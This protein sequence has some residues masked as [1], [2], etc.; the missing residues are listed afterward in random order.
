M[1]FLIA[2]DDENSRVLLESA[3]QAQGYTVDSAVN[4]A[5]A[6]ELARRTPPDMIISDI[7]MPEMDGFDLCRM[8]KEDERLRKIPF[9]FYSATY[10]EAK[11]KQLALSLGASRYIIKPMEM[12]EFLKI[13]AAVLEEHSAHKLPVPD[14]PNR[15]NHELEQMHANR[16]E[17]KLNQKVRALEKEREA[18]Q[19]SQVNLH[20][21]SRAVEQSPAAV[22][23]SDIHGNIEFVNNAFEQISGYSRK[24]VLGHKPS[25][26]KSE[27]TPPHVYDNLWL[28]ISTGREWRGEL[29]NKKRDGEL[30]WAYATISPI[31]GDDGSITHYL[32]TQEDISVRKEYEKRLLRQANF[33][34]ITGLPNRILVMD[35]LAQAI[36]SSQR[37][38][39]D[40]AVMMVDLDDF[41]KVNDTLGH[42]AGDQILIEAARRL[43]NVVRDLDTVARLGGDE[44]LLILPA[45]EEVTG[46]Q[47]VAEKI[48]ESFSTPFEIL[49]QVIVIT[50]SIGITHLL[51]DSKDPHILIRNAEAA[52][53]RA[54]HAGRNTYRFFIQELNEHAVKRLDMENQLRQALAKGEF[55][56]CYQPQL[57]T[58]SNKIVGAEALLHWQN[59]RLGLVPSDKFIHLAES[60]GL[61]DEI[62]L[63]VLDTAIR[64]AQQW[65]TGPDRPLRIAVNFS[66]QQFQHVDIVEQVARILR[67]SGLPTQLLEME[68]TESLLLRE[69]AN[70]L[71][72]LEQLHQ[73]GVRIAIDDFGTGYS[74]LSYLK[75]FPIDVLKIDQ[76][77]I[78]DVVDDPGDA[79]LVNTII[80][81][82]R[83]LGMQVIAEGVETE[84]Q[85]NFLKGAGCELVQGYYFSKPLPAGEF[86]TMLNSRSEM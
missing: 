77:F 56:L 3:L 61:I 57:E 49:G 50:A 54:K 48:L 36:A 53:Y 9:I 32:A 44:F 83:G 55:F 6:L 62:G 71:A 64:Q 69:E 21:L 60:I 74:A 70:V 24:E 72:K 35:R 30:Y 45:L 17:H 28:T 52:M 13:I 51:A 5:Q 19:E 58:G 59:P 76:S 39:R 85:L 65:Q 14:H 40:M 41:K 47:V 37:Q 78:R 63:W 82:A 42:P 8:V 33:D 80:A 1:R 31:L 68:I 46:S 66:S 12:V 16:L 25:L 7:L 10:T 81:M 4:G 84:G 67:D 20:K 22:I 34:D 18:L 27:N 11:D 29:Q 2:E 38:K 26:W 23:I 86:S 15:E 75:Q 43:S 73:L 79:V